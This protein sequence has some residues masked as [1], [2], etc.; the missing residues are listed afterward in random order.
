M[1]T[2]ELKNLNSLHRNQKKT[3]IFAKDQSGFKVLQTKAFEGT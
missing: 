2:L 1:Q 3:L